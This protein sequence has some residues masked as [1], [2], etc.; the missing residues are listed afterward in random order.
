MK[1]HISCEH[2]FDNCWVELKFTDGSMIAIDTISVE[3]EAAHHMYE[4]SE[5]DDLIPPVE[6]GVY[7]AFSA[8]KK[9]HDQNH[10][11]E[12]F[13]PC[14]ARSLMTEPVTDTAP[15]RAAAGTV[16]IHPVPPFPMPNPSH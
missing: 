3:S 10:A 13:I 7:S 15:Q 6:L 8:D 9:R 1:R 4:W 16:P 5:L 14:I 11:A 2:N 12:T